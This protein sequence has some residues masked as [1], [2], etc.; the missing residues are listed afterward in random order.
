[1]GGDIGPF[2]LAIVLTAICL[3]PIF[4]WRENYGGSGDD[5]E[6][7]EVCSLDGTCVKVAANAEQ[8]TMLGSLR[9]SLVLILE[10][11]AV[12]CLGL[13]QACFEGAV[14]TFGEHFSY[15]ISYPIVINLPDNS[16]VF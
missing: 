10:Q 1:M 13:S 2:Q 16:M 8:Q 6:P 9:A 3:V 15:Y 5:A 12:L 14:Y 4:F 11:P 7:L